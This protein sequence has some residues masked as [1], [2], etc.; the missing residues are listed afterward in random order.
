MKR[1]FEIE[2]PDEAGP[3]WMNADNLMLCINAYCKIKNGKI[4]AEDI[5]DN[6]KKLYQDIE[7]HN[8]KNA[9]VP[10]L[11][12]PPKTAPEGLRFLAHW[13]DEVYQDAGVNDR[14][15]RDLRKWAEEFEILA[16]KNSTS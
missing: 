10:T 14:V 7:I 2:W 9:S 3:L 5:T 8:R 12:D 6:I 11:E 13:F 15:Q 1:V 4:K 16:S